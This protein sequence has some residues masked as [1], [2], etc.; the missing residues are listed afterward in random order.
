MG[1]YHYTSK[2]K[3]KARD[4]R[5]LIILSSKYRAV[6]YNVKI[7]HFNDYNKSEGH[8]NKMELIKYVI[9]KTG[10]KVNWDP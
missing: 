6:K 5:K 2:N 1:S 4:I 9:E 10:D 7:I 3:L 8:R